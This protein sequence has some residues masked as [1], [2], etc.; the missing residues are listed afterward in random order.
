M[1]WGWGGSQLGARGGTPPP[2]QP[3][4][5]APNY[6]SHNAPSHPAPL[7]RGPWVQ[8]I[9]G[10]VVKTNWTGRGKER[11]ARG[12]KTRAQPSPVPTDGFALGRAPLAPPY[13][14]VLISCS[15]LLAFIFLLLT[16]LCCKRGD[17]GFKVRCTREV[18][19]G[20][21]TSARPFLR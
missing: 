10:A 20:R 14:V 5:K 13:A 8:S 16:C 21:N 11:G 18:K 17:V 6:N 1:G 19:V 9:M 12:V 4:E 2:T 15:G 3:L 7:P